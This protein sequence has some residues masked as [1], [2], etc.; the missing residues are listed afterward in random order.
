ME[1]Y[2]PFIS[3]SLFAVFFLY[4]AVDMLLNYSRTTGFMQAFGVPGAL[5]P[6]VIIFL[7]AASINIIFAWQLWWTCIGL[8][9]FCVLSGLIFHRNWADFND[10]MALLRNVTLV[11]AL[12][13]L[14]TAR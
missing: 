8:A 3:R 9:L 13:I 2:L 11:G 12:L 4:S 1:S 14:A 7:F 10:R 5:A 6:L